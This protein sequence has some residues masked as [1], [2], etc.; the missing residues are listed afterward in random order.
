MKDKLIFSILCVLAISSLTFGATFAYYVSS[1]SGTITGEAEGGLSTTLTLDTVYKASRLVPLDDSLVMTA[2]SKD[3]NKCIDRSNYE[4]CSLYEI[5][6][7]NTGNSEILYGYIR[8]NTSTYTTDNLKY[9]IFD[10]SYNNLTDVITLS[11]TTDTT[12][13]FQKNLSNYTLT[14]T[15]TTTYYLAIWLTDTGLEQSDDYSKTFS[16]YIGFESVEHFGSDT[17]KIEAGFNT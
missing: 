5:T 4:V 9:Q 12:V 2:V 7:L 16:G 17:G 6:L 14:S 10:S 1:T 13:Y 11:Q 3:T 15:G 8:T